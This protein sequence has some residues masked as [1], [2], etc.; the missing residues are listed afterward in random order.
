MALFDSSHQEPSTG[1]NNFF[2]GLI[3]GKIFL[4]CCYVPVSK[5]SDTGL[6][7]LFEPHC[8]QF[9]FYLLEKCKTRSRTK[10]ATVKHCSVDLVFDFK[11]LTNGIFKLKQVKCFYQISWRWLSS[12]ILL[13]TNLKVN[14]QAFE[15][16][17]KKFACALYRPVKRRRDKNVGHLKISHFKNDFLKFK[18]ISFGK[19]S[20]NQM[21]SNKK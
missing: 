3:Y 11:K 13:G 9:W 8:S 21:F 6:S 5:N 10:Q 12:T 17:H 19:Y 2:K 1:I 14:N 4:K 15:S 7:I 18:K 16:A 20:N